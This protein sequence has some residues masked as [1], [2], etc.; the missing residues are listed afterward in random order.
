LREFGDT[1]LWLKIFLEPTWLG[2][3]TWVHTRTAS[4]TDMAL[5]TGLSPRQDPIPPFMRLTP[6]QI[7]VSHE[8][9]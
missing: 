7:A 3:L 2:R 8:L 6:G 1:D 9:I 5:L 4:T